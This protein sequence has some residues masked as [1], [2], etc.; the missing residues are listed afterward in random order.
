MELNCACFKHEHL[1]FRL[2]PVPAEQVSEEK[3]Y[4][5]LILQTSTRLEL[6]GTDS[7]YQDC[8]EALPIPKKLT[9]SFPDAAWRQDSM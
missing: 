3:K 4:S 9:R 8:S 5:T 7:K 2:N 1:Q 6:L